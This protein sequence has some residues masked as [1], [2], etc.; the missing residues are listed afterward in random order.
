MALRKFNQDVTVFPNIG[1]KERKSGHF[2][3][4]SHAISVHFIAIV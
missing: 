2:L 1:L 4:K 3:S